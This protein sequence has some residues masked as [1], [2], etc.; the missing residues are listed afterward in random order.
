MNRKRY[1]KSSE[2]GRSDGWYVELA[3]V[4]VAELTDAQWSDMFWDSYAITA[5]PGDGTSPIFDD[6]N[7][8][9]CRFKFRSRRTGELVSTAFAGRL[10]PIVR[11][12]RVVIR[13]LYLPDVPAE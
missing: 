2:Y 5:I 9:Y 4:R 8:R 7:W 10:P 3:G 12:G 11:D 1:L 6:D 13:G